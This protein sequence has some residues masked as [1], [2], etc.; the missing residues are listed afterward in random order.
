MPLQPLPRQY[1]LGLIVSHVPVDEVC[2]DLISM[3]RMHARQHP[4][5]PKPRPKLSPIFC[6]KLVFCA[7]VVPQ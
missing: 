3:V 2:L 4:N 7:A 5:Q 1:I 6:I